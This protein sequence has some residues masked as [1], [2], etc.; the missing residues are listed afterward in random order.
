[1]RIRKH[2]GLLT[3]C[4]FLLTF[5]ISAGCGGQTMGSGGGGGSTQSSAQVSDKGVQEIKRKLETY[6]V[7]SKRV[8]DKYSANHTATLVYDLTFLPSKGEGSFA[9]AGDS[10]PELGGNPAITLGGT[11]YTLWYHPKNGQLLYELAT[12]DSTGKETGTGDFVPIDG[13]MENG[14]TLGKFMKSAKPEDRTLA[15]TLLL[16]LRMKAKG[17]G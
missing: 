2:L 17:E 12:V 1:M 13:S 14:A 7:F 15:G 4:A 6:S 16:N 11:T 5:L 3:F 10:N 8:A 9:L